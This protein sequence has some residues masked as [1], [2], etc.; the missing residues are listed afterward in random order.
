MPHDQK[1]ITI[2]LKNGSKIFPLEVT[3]SP[4]DGDIDK[5]KEK[6]EN[7][8]PSLEYRNGSYGYSYITYNNETLTI[9]PSYIV[10][11]KELR[12]F[13]K[14]NKPNSN[15]NLSDNLVSIPPAAHRCR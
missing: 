8:L 11:L 15:L 9:P 13:I 1:T 7:R 6:I 3:V 12:D 5:V 4:S 14:Q 2:N 10:S